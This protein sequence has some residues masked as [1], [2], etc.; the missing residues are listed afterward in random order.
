LL[1]LGCDQTGDYLPPQAR[2]SLPACVVAGT[3]VVMDASDSVDEDG[4]IVKYIYT[5][6]HDHAPLVHN[7][8]TLTYVF[9]EPLVDE[10]LIQQYLVRLRVTDDHGLSD[11]VQTGVFVVFNESECEE[12]GATPP[13]VVPDVVEPPDMYQA[14][15]VP[16]VPPEMGPQDTAPLD[17]DVPPSDTPVYCPNITGIYRVQVFC[18]GALEVELEL[19]LLQSADCT[20]VDDFGIVSGEVGMDGTIHLWSEH[21]EL[22]IEDCQGTLEDPE[23]FTLDCTSNCTAVFILM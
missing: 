8:P 15:V 6:G 12:V 10:G 5:I 11:E 16:D 20:F 21:S 13:P 18:F 14:D 19:S 17:A 3:K 2:L 22:N 1:L 9:K 7:Q 4:R 23:Q